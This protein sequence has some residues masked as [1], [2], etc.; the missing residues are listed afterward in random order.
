ME[1]TPKSKQT[2]L[3][4]IPEDWEVGTLSNLLFIKGRIGWKGLKKSEFSKKGIVI[5]NGPNIKNKRVDWNS[6]LRV[7]QWR[8]EESQEIAVQENDILMT[9]DGTIGKIA[10]IEHLPEIATL[11]SGIFL[12]RSK[13]KT[14]NQNFLYHYF[15]SSFFKS[16]V[17]SRIEGSVIPH[18]YQR[19]ME[20]LSILLP[21]LAEQQKI[22]KILTNLDFQIKNL[23]KQNK[24]L[25]KIAQAIFKSWFVDFDGVIEFQDS[26]LG[27]IPKGWKTG[28]LDIITN[29]L[30]DTINVKDIDSNIFYIG[31]EH[32]PRGRIE[33]ANWENAVDLKSNKF[34]F[35]TNQILFGKL[36]PYFK[37]VGIALI[38]GI[39]STDIL[40]L[41]SKDP[42]WL[43]FLLFVVSSE[44]FIQYANQSSTGTRMPRADWNFMKKYP[45]ILPTSSKISEFH[46]IIKNHIEM[47]KK[48][49]FEIISLTKTRDIL[50][51]KLMSG[52]IRV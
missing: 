14:L 21:P 8:Y 25:E 6:C 13:S 44:D 9:K 17:D 26:E 42:I 28:I 52:E 49:I 19:D 38:D 31:L 11:A 23:Q 43:E 24:V 40:V 3:G 27:Q 51:P 50:L 29:N 7:P 22:A 39:C 45:I 34:K 37:K 15:N 30:R 16:L 32:M 5:I 48:N 33:L 2:E 36:R 4:A 10:Y 46:Q 47:I 35:K 1:Q 41:D 20:Q 18:L 12:I